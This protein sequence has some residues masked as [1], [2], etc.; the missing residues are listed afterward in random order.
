M[1]GVPEVARHRPAHVAEPYEA[2]V[3][4]I[5]PTVALVFSVLSTLST[6]L[7]KSDLAA[8]YRDRGKFIKNSDHILK[9]M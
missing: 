4:S 2:D 3:H 8:S 5:P 6:S 1:A 7:A 9:H